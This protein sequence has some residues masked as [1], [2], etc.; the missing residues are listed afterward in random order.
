MFEGDMEEIKIDA[1]D[2]VQLA[3]LALTGGQKDIQMFVRRLINRYRLA[4]PELSD[5]LGSLLRKSAVKNPESPL[6]NASVETMPVDLDSRLQL[7]R[8]EDPVQL[9]TVPV[10][11]GVVQAQLSQII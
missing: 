9:D 1:R 3:R 11:Q 2:L 4:V 10:W 6:R 8:T 5:Q 7:A